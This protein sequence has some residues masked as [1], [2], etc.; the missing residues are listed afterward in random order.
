[1]KNFTVI[2]KIHFRKLQKI[3]LNSVFV[4]K[5]YSGKVFAISQKGDLHPLVIF[6]HQTPS[7]PGTHLHMKPMRLSWHVPPFWQWITLQ[8]LDECHTG[9]KVICHIFC[10][11]TF[12]WNFNINQMINTIVKPMIFFWICI[13]FATQF[14]YLYFNYLPARV[15][16]I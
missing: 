3:F 9:S 7:N 4:F 5:N 1:M 16:V 14:E 13:L 2:L 10:Y 8:S 11:R 6:S 12:S 15:C